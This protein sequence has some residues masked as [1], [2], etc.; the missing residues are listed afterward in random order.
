[1]ARA[2]YVA[3]S[4]ARHTHRPW[5][6]V[7]AQGNYP[8]TGLYCLKGAYLTLKVYIQQGGRERVIS[9]GYPFAIRRSSSADVRI[10][11]LCSSPPTCSI[12]TYQE[13]PQIQPNP[14]VGKNSLNGKAPTAPQLLSDGHVLGLRGT[15]I[16]CRL[17]NDS[18]GLL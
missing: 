5:L 6:A 4:E 16:C 11:E 10:R 3:E 17:T 8:T 13:K 1:M 12:V 14:A 2:G 7:A 18:F 15:Q 9:T